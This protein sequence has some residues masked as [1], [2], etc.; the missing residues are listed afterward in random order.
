MP[1]HE[2]DANTEL[3]RAIAHTE[4]SESHFRLLVESVS[5]YAIF[6][7]DP[8]GVVLT[9]NKGAERYK[10]YR[11]EE[12]IGQSFT[13]FYTP[14]DQAAG[15]P[16]R[17]LA[18]A[19]EHGHVEDEG[20]RVRQDGTRFWAAVVFTAL[21]DE[22]G[23]LVGYAKVTR[24]LTERRQAEEHRRQ[25][26]LLVQSVS[27]YAIL[28][29]TPEGTVAS[30][31]PG[32]ETVKGYTES[33]ILGLPYER[34]FTPE[35]IAEGKPRALLAKA[36]ELG[37]IEDEGWRVR[38]DGTRFWALA[39]ITAIRDE[40]GQFV[41]YSKVTRDLTERKRAEEAL[42]SHA[43][44]LEE[45]NR[46]LGSQAEELQVQTEELQAQSEELQAQHEELQAQHEELHATNDQ[47]R[48]LADR[49]RELD[50]LKDQFLSILSH[51]LR[52]P[53]NAIL[54]F[55]SILDDE[56]AGPLTKEQHEFLAKIMRGSEVLLSLITDLLDMSRIQAGSFSLS[57]APTDAGELAGEVVDTLRVLAERK[58]Q[59]LTCRLEPA[60]PTFTA[61][62]QRLVQVLIN[63]ANNAIKF[64]PE[65]ARITLRACRQDEGVRFEVEDNGPGIDA[66]HLPRL[67]E[68]FTQLDMSNS[69]AV[70]G[71]GLGLSIAK[72]LIEAH[73]GRI[74]VESTPGRG[75]TVWFTVPLQP[76]PAHP[77]PVID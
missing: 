52:T 20:W 4:P 51:E 12:I 13:R 6:M 18:E 38:K 27:D 67:F 54:G 39:V 63:L 58:Q 10:G 44:E 65:G 3:S 32:V 49:L 19:R 35:A 26:E 30:W 43:R 57:L 17:L 46:R 74:G 24:D 47:L 61:D 7:L 11:A 29:L 8:A 5:D 34:F 77:T 59:H 31:N 62:R 21:W 25:F 53:L 36:R 16:A 1:P 37:H 40:Q 2:R 42:A 68:R 69:R 28:M 41:G 33:E 55:A 60:L 23:E 9:W 76:A 45:A 22:Q 72:A 56:V 66:R 64:S 50:T 73:G 15:R 71:T 75:S 70:T 14:E 48:E